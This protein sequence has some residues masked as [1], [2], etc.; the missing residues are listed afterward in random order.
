MISSVQFSHSVVSNSLQPHGRQ[1]TRPP[2]P[3]QTPGVYLNSCPL[4]Q[5]CHPTISSSVVPFSSCPQSFPKIR[6]VSSESALCMRCPKYWSFS[7]KI[8]FLEDKHMFYIQSYRKST[9]NIIGR[10][11]AKNEAQILWTPD[12]KSW[13]T[14]K[15][16]NA[17]KDYRQKENGV[18]E[19]KM[20]R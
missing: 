13:L 6:V 10:T 12:T 11:D 14:G 16:M 20:F 19:D 2:C 17:W 4:S 18:A 9:M 5:W 1:H 15:D 7:F 3:S 8:S